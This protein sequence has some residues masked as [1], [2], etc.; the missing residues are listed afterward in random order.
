MW[1]QERWLPVCSGSWRAGAAGAGQ[2]GGLQKPE[3]A[4]ENSIETCILS[5]VKYIAN[6][7]SVQK[8]GYSGLVQ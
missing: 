8:T 6:P 1:Q 4:R 3:E 5:Y 2:A 7:G